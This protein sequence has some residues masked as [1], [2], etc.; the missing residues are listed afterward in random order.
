[1]HLSKHSNKQ[2]IHLFIRFVNSGYAPLPSAGYVMLRLIYFK[3][4][5]RDTWIIG[6]CGVTPFIKKYQD[7]HQIVSIVVQTK[8][9]SARCWEIFDAKI[10]CQSHFT[11]FLF[12]HLMDGMHNLY[13]RCLIISRFCLTFNLLIAL[14]TSDLNMTGSW[15]GNI[16]ISNFF[17]GCV[18][19]AV[20]FTVI[21]KILLH[22]NLRKFL[23]NFW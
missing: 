7:F 21:I 12:L 2:V 13:F 17:L 6:F 10:Y 23:Q 19:I 16:E 20:V 3:V 8:Q 5:S 15:M 14:T 11:F 22:Y 1:M 9:L 4:C 18:E